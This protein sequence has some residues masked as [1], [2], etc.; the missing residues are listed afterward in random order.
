MPSNGSQNRR[1][2]ILD[3]DTP[4]QVAEKVLKALDN[5][6]RLRILRFLSNRIASI[7]EIA[8]ALDIPLSSTALHVEILEEAGLV[9][10]EFEPASRG[11]QKVCSRM[12]DQIVVDLPV[13]EEARERFTEFSMPIGAYVDCQAQPTCGILNDTGIIGMLDDPSSFYEPDHFN[14]QLLWFHQGYVE[15]RFPNRIPKNSVPS[16]VRLSMEVCSEAPLY[17]LNWPSDITVWINGVEL[18]SWTSPS[19]FGG[20]PGRLTPEWWT[21]RNTQYGLLKFWHVDNTEARVD[22]INISSV[23]IEDLNL[24]AAPFISVR[25]GVKAD[26]ANVGGLNL[27]GSRFGNY[28]Q[29]LVLGISYHSASQPLPGKEVIGKEVVEKAVVAAGP[30]GVIFRK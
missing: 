12:Y 5:S 11:L 29:D 18:G 17:N 16:V 30:A 23:T 28:P 14:A 4:P 22:G 6:N 10:G 2:I 27:F 1:I 25:I 26:A 3:D 15:Y 19:D 7:S 20:E 24:D 13:I 8:G 21:P 9:R